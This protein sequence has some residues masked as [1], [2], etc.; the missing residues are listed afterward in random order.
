MEIG[1]EI[2]KKIRAA[3]K[4][5]LQEL[6]AYVDEELPDYIMVMVANKKTSQQMSDD[7]S[8]FLGNNTIK[9]TVWLH[10]VLEKL[11]SVAVGKFRLHGVLEKL[12]SV[13][14][15]KF[16]LHGVPEKLRSVAVGKFRLHG[17]PEKLR[18]VAVGKFRL[19]G[20]PE[21]L[22]S[23]AVGKFRL[24][25]VPE[26][27]RSVAVGKFRLHGV[28][29]KLRSVAVGKFRLHGVL[30][31]LR[32]VAVEPASLRPQ[33]YSDTGTSS[34]KSEW[35]GEESKGLAVSSSRS[36]RTEARVSSSA[37]EH[38]RVSSDKTS[39]RLT[40]TVK[41]L[42]DPPSSE[43]VIDIKP[44]LDDDLIGEDPVDMGVLPGRLRGS[45]SGGRASAQIYRPPQGRSSSGTGRSADAYRSSEGSS[46]SHSRQQHSSYHLDSRSSRDSRTYREGGSSRQQ[47]EASRKRKAPVVS[48]VVRVNQAA[49]GGRDSDDDDEEEDDD[50][51]DEGYGVKNL[52]SRVSLPSKP[53]RKPSLPP[54]KQANKNLLLRA[55]SEAQISI[56]KT[57][58][59]LPIPQRQTV[60]VAP[61]TRSTTDEMNAAIQLVQEHLHGLVPRGQ[62]YTPSEPQPPRQLVVQSRSLAS[63]L[64]LDV[65][66]DNMR[67]QHSDYLALEVAEGSVLKPFDTR[68]FIVRRP[69]LE[70]ELVPV[71]NRLGQLDRV[72]MT[73]RLG[74]EEMPPPMRSGL[75][76]VA[77][78][79]RSRLGLEEVAPPM[80]SRREETTVPMRSRLGAM[81][82]EEIQPATPRMVQPASS[83]K[84]EATGS[85]SPKFIVTLDGVPSPLGNLGDCDMEADDSYPKP[86]KTTM[87]DPS[88][89]LGTKPK[90]SIH[91]RLQGEPQY[92]DELG[93]ETEEEEEEAGPVKRQ[94]VLERCKFWPVCKSGDECV[95]HHPTTQ[96]KTFPSCKFGDK[97]LFVHPNCKFDGK[98]SKPDCP[99]THVSR[100]G[101]APYTPPVRPVPPVQTSSVCRFFPECKKMDCLFYHP[102]P[103]RFGAQC[104]RTGC[105]FYHPTASVPPRHALKW[106]KAQSS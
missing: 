18:S 72:P 82:K 66:E 3:I 77:P 17:V 102:K 70:E 2:S 4:G 45:T 76:E 106:T 24:H 29:E 31:K 91:H 12:R 94:K 22:R 83:E 57:A 35:K 51:E 14:V 64:Q 48:S 85:A 30:E 13:A 28:P 71:R 41:P 89:H 78:P 58:A 50:E 74:L 20:V 32:S 40:S 15:G 8:L 53:E 105:T 9:F 87:P 47:E 49:D 103:C 43:A 26:K 98:C 92:P 23:V 5:K 37:H 54:A 104:K 80:R 79:M 96:C 25:G 19:H 44:E 60:P 16:R 86:A 34:G 84:A 95:Y 88:I 93:M 69:E 99:F 33:L 68:S 36:D 46:G 90:L 81:V 6:G 11:R 27:L 42:M 10:G 1:T 73:S 65:P 52:S 61:R 97:C 67:A 63:R 62:S 21:K 101:P 7:L 56:N 39:S 38:R 59:Y 75:E 100:R 55:M